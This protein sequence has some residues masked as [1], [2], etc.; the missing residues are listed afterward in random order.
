[1]AVFN[2]ADILTVCGMISCAL[3]TVFGRDHVADPR[4]A[5]AVAEADDAAVDPA[6][7]TGS[8]PTDRA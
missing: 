7:D 4:D 6:P 1:F 5:D 3:T 2:V 8:A